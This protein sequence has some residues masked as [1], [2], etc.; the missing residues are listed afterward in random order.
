MQTENYNLKGGSYKN[1]ISLQVCM[2][3]DL[4]MKH[5]LVKNRLVIAGISNQL[6]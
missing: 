2:M 6:K 3:E 1:F 4:I 5:S